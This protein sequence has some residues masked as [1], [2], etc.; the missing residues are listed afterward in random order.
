LSVQPVAQKP[1]LLVQNYC[2][3]KIKQ[4]LYM[5]S[6]CITSTYTHNFATSLHCTAQPSN[7]YPLL[8]PLIPNNTYLIFRECRFFTLSRAP[9]QIYESADSNLH[10]LPVP[11]LSYPPVF[12]TSFPPPVVCHTLIRRNYF[13]LFAFRA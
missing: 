1:L 2:C 9:L 5:S 3:C 10:L 4:A 13:P 7:T 8:Q 12:S 6:Y 11:K